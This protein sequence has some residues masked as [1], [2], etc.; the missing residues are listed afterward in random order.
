MP[1][2]EQGF[3]FLGEVEDGQLPPLVRMP[4]TMP[5]LQALAPKEILAPTWA[6]WNAHFGVDPRETRIRGEE[7][8]VVKGKQ[9]TAL[10]YVIIFYPSTTFNINR[11]EAPHSYPP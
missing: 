2:S 10:R 8:M 11:N 3:G 9:I 4:D 6:K 7:L 1:W 5:L